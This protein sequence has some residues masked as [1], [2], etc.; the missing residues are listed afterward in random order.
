MRTLVL[1]MLL[2]AFAV[3]LVVGCSDDPVKPSIT[4][5]HASETCGVA[6]LRVDFRVDATGGVAE[7]QPT[8]SNNWLSIEWNFGDGTQSN[9]ATA[10]AYHIYEVPGFYTVT[11]KVTD[12]DGASDLDSLH[13]LARADTLDIEILGRVDGEATTEIEICRPFEMDIIGSACGFDSETDNQ[14]RFVFT[15]TVGDSTYAGVGP[16]HTFHP[17]VLDDDEAVEEI[18][19][20]VFDPVLD[21]FRSASSTLDAVASEGADLTVAVDWSNS[22]LQPVDAD[23]IVRV[24]QQFPDLLTYTVTLRNDGLANGYNVRVDGEL[25]TED[26]EGDSDVRMIHLEGLTDV[27]SYQHYPET[28]DDD[29]FWTWFVPVVPAGSEVTLDVRVL[30]EGADKFDLY[31]FPVDIQ[32]YWC[33]AADDDNSAEAVYQIDSAPSDLMLVASW[34]GNAGGGFD[35]LIMRQVPAPGFP[36]EVGYTMSVINDGPSDGFDVVVTG[37]LPDD[38]RVSF[39]GYSVPGNTTFEYD[40]PSRTWTWTLP[41]AGALTNGTVFVSIEATPLDESYDFVASIAPYAEDPTPE[42]HDATAT[43]TVYTATSDLD[44]VTTWLDGDG[45]VL[46]VGDLE[47]DILSFPNQLNLRH[48]LTND[49]PYLARGLVIH[50]DLG[51]STDAYRILQDADDFEFNVSD[52]EFVLDTETYQWIWTLGELD[53]GASV[54]L[55]LTFDMDLDVEVM[56][57]GSWYVLT[58]FLELFPG[59]PDLDNNVVTSRMAI[60]SLPEK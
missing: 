28:D 26:A 40:E 27:G 23:T 48:E 51:A 37:L 8:G 34:G 49:G 25:P 2:M 15:W 21:I 3:L 57:P 33:D 24:V 14:D 46:S 11:C 19:V 56:A 53:N 35:P 22:P 30:F 58:S 42:D 1:T 6:P 7:D 20:T 4:R 44:L 38:G 39:D 17:S 47:H 13:V 5:L 16:V 45:A 52:G 41:R 31:S 59:D 9:D 32:E 50:G 55:D 60:R 54:T 43:Y 36:D 29:A 18:S 12:A 10:V